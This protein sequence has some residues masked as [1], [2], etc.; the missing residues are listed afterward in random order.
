[1][2]PNYPGPESTVQNTSVESAQIAHVEPCILVDMKLKGF[3]NNIPVVA[4]K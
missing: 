4:A 1:M 2:D 3:I